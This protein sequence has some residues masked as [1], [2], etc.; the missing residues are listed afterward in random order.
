MP[1]H[2]ASARR[3]VKTV[4]DMNENQYI[5]GKVPFTYFVRGVGKQPVDGVV[6]TGDKTRTNSVA[7]KLIEYFP[8]SMACRE[9]C[10]PSDC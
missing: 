10:E 1:P 3:I 4:E 2:L 6:V 5:S 7:I 9:M 8:K